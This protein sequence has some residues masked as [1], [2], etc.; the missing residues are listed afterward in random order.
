MIDL[1]RRPAGQLVSTPAADGLLARD[2]GLKPLSKDS[3]SW[4]IYLAKCGLNLA[5]PEQNLLKGKFTTS[6]SEAFPIK[7]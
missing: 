3:F 2:L 6:R 5:L 4:K 1:Q 7:H